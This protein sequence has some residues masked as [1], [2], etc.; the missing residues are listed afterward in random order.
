MKSVKVI[1]G[2]DQ[3]ND[4]DEKMK[5]LQAYILGYKN[6]NHWMGLS[7]KVIAQRSR[8]VEILVALGPP[9]NTL[10]SRAYQILLPQRSKD[11][12]RDSYLILSGYMRHNFEVQFASLAP[13]MQDFVFST[14][15]FLVRD[16]LSGV[17]IRSLPREASFQQNTSTGEV[18]IG[19]HLSPI[20]SDDNNV[21]NLEGG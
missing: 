21:E 14:T 4:K 16:S 13:L 12:M 5:T 20:V 2:L 18:S 19:R 1:G 17:H 10:T 3:P 15:Q 9:Y 8:Q 11:H 6:E 7:H